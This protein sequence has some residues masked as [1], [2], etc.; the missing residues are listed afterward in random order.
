[1]K[2]PIWTTLALLAVAGHAE[3]LRLDFGTEASPLRDGFTASSPAAVWPE[4]VTLAAKANPI[5]REWTY[6]ESS[7]RNNPP[8]SYSNELTGDHVESAAPATL[9]LQVPDGDYWVWLLCG[10]AGGNASQVWD[11]AVDSGSDQAKATFAGGYE[12][13]RLL[14]RAK[15]TNG[16]V[17]LRFATRSRWLLNAL[18]LVPEAEWATTQADLLA[19]LE[20]EVFVLPPDVLKEWQ[21][22]AQPPAGEEPA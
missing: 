15:A 16:R 4:D 13:R 9:T 2:H 6:S 11:I 17:Q 12:T 14:L 7:G 22:V 19:P 10:A 21:E 20:T 1:M 5:Q 18:V 3:S 8:A